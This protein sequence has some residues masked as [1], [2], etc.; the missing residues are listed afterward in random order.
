LIKWLERLCFMLK[1][2]VRI[3]RD[4]ILKHSK[5]VFPILIIA[6][7]A[8]TL[9]IV[10]NLGDKRT[11]EI[12]PAD[13]TLKN[14]AIESEEIVSEEVP[15]IPNENDAITTLIT[16]YYNAT[17]S[18]DEETLR[19]VCD[20]IG[21]AEMLRI[22]E[23]SKYIDSCPIQDIYIKQGPEEGTSIVYVYYK[24]MFTNHEEA[25][26]GYQAHYVCTADDGSL[27]IRRG[28][29][30]EAVNEYIQ[31]VNNQS[32]VI[33]FNNRINVEYNE[34]MEA[35]PE[36][37]EFLNELNTAV[38]TAT[39]EALA[40]QVGSENPVE[41]TSEQN[42]AQNTETNGEEQTVVEDETA[43]E[44]P[45]VNVVEYVTT[46]D[47]VNVRASDS[48]KATKLGKASKGTTLQVVEQ[49][50]NG[51]TKLIFEGKEGFIKS[52]YLKL[53]EN[54]EA[55]S[56]IG[57]V[58]ATTSI[59]VRAEASETADKF[60]VLAGGETV[61]LLSNENGWCKINYNGK[62]G[63]VKADYVQQN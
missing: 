2:K 24:V 25:F 17:A 42:E 54:V 12:L 52:E 55:S 5:L 62:I 63:F 48:E 20:E 8:I 10:L 35:H 46:T 18:G 28:E 11:E 31:N 27:Y 22:I 16:E 49:Q 50:V 56:V 7:V 61:D 44:T 40:E 47:T 19:N 58:T 23:T 34:L 4:Y 26:P 15:L 29:N 13:L 37:L 6:A 9:T 33:D 53:V 21:D 14:E 51:W 32:D 59:N 43:T 41:E 3:A 1:D 57:T 38:N 36:L 45:V 30:S 60:G 39:G